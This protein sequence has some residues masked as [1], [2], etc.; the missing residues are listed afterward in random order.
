M[1]PAKVT[2]AIFSLANG[3]V[4]R[5]LPFSPALRGY[6]DFSKTVV[7]AKTAREPAAINAGSAKGGA[8][9]APGLNSHENQRVHDCPRVEVRTQGLQGGICRGGK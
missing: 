3:A 1:L 7:V 2:H 8:V 6:T 9:I 4:R 5:A